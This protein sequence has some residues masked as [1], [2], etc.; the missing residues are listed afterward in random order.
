MGLAQPIRGRVG[1]LHVIVVDRG[2]V[3]SRGGSKKGKMFPPESIIASVERNGAK[4]GLT[5]NIGIRRL[6]SAYRHGIRVLKE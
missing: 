4:K 5:D 2:S 6:T 1:P 3:A